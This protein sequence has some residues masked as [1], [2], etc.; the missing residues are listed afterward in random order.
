MRCTLNRLPLARRAGVFQSCWAAVLAAICLSTSSA[1]SP[2]QEPVD[3]VPALAVVSADG[4]RAAWVSSEGRSVLSAT[5]ANATA[6]WT[7]PSRLLTVRGRVGKM[8]FSANGQSLAFENRRSWRDSGAATDQWQFISVYDLASRNISHV[9]PSFDIDTNPSWSENGREV[10][11]TRQVEGLAPARL[12]RPIERL[13]RNSWQPPSV[14]PGERYTMADALAAPFIHPPVPSADG[15]VIAYIAR[16]GRDRNIYRLRLGESA[17]RWVNHPN[18]DG[19]DLKELAVSHTGAAIAYVRGDS[20]NRQ[21]DAPNPNSLPDLPQQQVWLMADSDPAPR[22]LAA[23]HS[24]L[25]TP[26]SRWL[27]W[28]AQGNWRAVSLGWQKGRLVSVG[29]PLEFL[30]GE[31]DGLRFSP[32]GR[33]VAYLRGDSIE[34]LDLATRIAVA[35]PRDTQVDSG[36]VWSPDSKRLVYRRESADSP[37]LT[38]NDCGV[39]RYCGPMVSAQP[40]SLWVVD[41]ANLQPRQIWQAE[42]GIGS[43]YYGLDQ[44]LSPG[45][46]GDQLFWSTDNRI[47]FVWERDG[48]RHLYAVSADGGKATLLTP[49][50]GEVETATLSLDRKTLIYATN[51]GDLGRRHLFSVGFDGSPPQRL[52][53]GDSSQWSPTTLFDGR[54]AYIDAGWA[55]AARVRIRTAAGVTSSVSLPEVPAS[56]PKTQLVRPELVEFSAADGQPAFGQL[57][58]P[59]QS[60]GCAIVYAHGGIRR[61]MLPGLHYK[62]VYQHLYLMNQYLA[63]R[64][65]VVLSVAYRSSLMRGQAYRNAPGWGFSANSELQDFLG[66]ATFLKARKDVGAERGVG[67]YG[68]SWGGYVTALALAKHSDVFT[69][70][71]DM[72]GVHTATDSLGQAHSA[73]AH[74]EHWKSPVYLVHGD[75]DLNVDINESIE[76]ARNLQRTRPDVLV[77]QRLVPGHTHD[78][79]QS[80]EQL[81]DIYTEGS[82]FLLQHLRIQ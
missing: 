25:F 75:D 63:S 50:D 58:V 1:S 74:V 38:R 10:S 29:E 22:L 16:E 59:T 18:D 28:Q 17:R 6:A 62:E 9:D 7:A 42:P 14:R 3:F 35:I 69:V 8:V 26:D 30:T 37:G 52:T 46:F 57:F 49:G 66:A 51:I 71:F 15:H 53:S 68:L 70:G 79:N 61:Q 23:G 48:W 36:P 45:Q 31:R 82:D 32:D 65:C 11:F 41:V 20:H 78:L 54:L 33:K 72:A 2:V 73:V 21:G 43:V 4:L 60:T 80:H 55:E 77:K 40:W 67:I 24:P 19:R 27:L 47:G 34:V 56:F 12:S 13:Q 39:Y 5:R 44:A 64:G 81:V 76:L